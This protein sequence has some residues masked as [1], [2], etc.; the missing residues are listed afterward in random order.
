MILYDEFREQLPI[1]PTDS[2]ENYQ[3]TPLTYFDE[4]N[5]MIKTFDNALPIEYRAWEKS[6]I[7][8]SNMINL[9]KTE[10]T[11]WIP[12]RDCRTLAT[13]QKEILGEFNIFK[14][15]NI[16]I[17]DRNRAINWHSIFPFNDSI[18]LKNIMD[19]H[20][21]QFDLNYKPKYI[22][23]QQNSTVFE[24]PIEPHMIPIRKE[25][26]TIHKR[27]NSLKNN[28]E[29]RLHRTR[30][31]L[32]RVGLTGV[33]PDNHD[34]S[35]YHH[36]H[37]DKYKETIKI[38]STN[39]WNLSNDFYYDLNTEQDFQSKRR[40]N[41]LQNHNFIFYPIFRTINQ[42]RYFHHPLLHYSN[43]DHRWISIQLSNMKTLD[44]SIRIKSDL[45]GICGEILFFEYS[46]QYPVLLNE[47]GMFSKIRTYLRPQHFKADINSAEIDYGE[48][49]YTHASPFLWSIP[50]GLNI[51]TIEN[52]MFL[53]PVYRQICLKNDFLIIINRKREFWIRNINRIYIIGQQCP[54][55][56]VPI[57]QSKRV[58]LFQRDLLQIYIYRLFLQSNE[59]PRRIR[60]DDIKRVFPRMAES[61]IRKRLK[62][63]ADFR[64][65]DD[66]N[67]WI[68]RNDF[69]LPTEDEIHD[70]IKP[71]FCC[72]YA[73]MT[74]AEQR[75]KG[76]SSLCSIG[77]E[78]KTK[79]I[80]VS[81]DAGF[82]DKYNL[83]FDDEDD[84]EQSNHL[85]E[86]DDEILQAPWNTTRAYLSA[87]KGKCSIHA[88]GIGAKTI[89]KTKNNNDL[90]HL[91]RAVTGTDADLRRLQL[92]DARKLLL[93]FN[94]SDK[95]IQSLTRWEI[96][97]LVRTLSTQQ[98]KEGIGG[99]ML[100]YARGAKHLQAQQF[101]KYKENYQKQFELQNQLFTCTDQQ[102]TDEDLSDES[103]ELLDEM[104][105]TL[106]NLL[107]EHTTVSIS[108]KYKKMLHITRTYIDNQGESY[109]QEEFIRNNDSV[110]QTYIKIRQNK[111]DKFIKAYYALDNNEREKLKRE[112]R[113]LQEQLRRVK[114]NEARYNQYEKQQMLLEIQQQNLAL[115]KSTQAYQP[116]LL[117]S[118]SI[119]LQRS[120][121]VLSN[122]Q[123]SMS[124]DDDN[125][126]SSNLNF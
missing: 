5:K 38:K 6:I 105:Q 25:K 101:E 15:R 67:S 100:K 82:R 65:T 41:S 84:D 10:E 27:I 109:Q 57:P 29:S 96:V 11:G 95:I 78:D 126:S 47:I 28:K 81:I 12:T 34:D 77:F 92:K 33:L 45:T 80:I 44:K 36:H 79:F 16:H 63:S 62:T 56:E 110:I 120:T 39:F 70:L 121:S 23:P 59:I 90:K 37:H 24:I 72:A 52:N 73:S 108:N 94:I 64:R 32:A 115:I 49:I 83:G 69:R 8:H 9:S 98:A 102:L 18:I 123:L 21:F 113:R 20:N 26:T 42:L 125:S 2:I 50:R 58:N 117:S 1:S 68:L 13:Y 4:Q 118:K 76:I 111:S 48:L 114:R 31:V 122:L 54:L 91:R 124:E 40:L 74:A 19:N 112:R 93:K 53:A 55:I 61:S 97:D 30:N 107:R 86:L 17:D 85:S 71:E 116:P 87:L 75:L 35:H 7:Y 106:E 14:F 3:I 46:E 103:D 43:I 119:T 99:G 89:H 66:C 104:S 88:F 51:Q 22:N 60:I